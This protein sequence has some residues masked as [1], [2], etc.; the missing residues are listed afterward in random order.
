MPSKWSKSQLGDLGQMDRC[1]L[2]HIKFLAGRSNIRSSS[3]IHRGIRANI[4]MTWVSG[5]KYECNFCVHGNVKFF[6]KF[7]SVAAILFPLY[8][9]QSVA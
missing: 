4:L 9:T 5:S 3:L 7:L 6:S 1:K 8:D 2:E